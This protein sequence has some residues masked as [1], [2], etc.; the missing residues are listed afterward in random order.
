MYAYIKETILNLAKE[1]RAFH[2][3]N[4]L[5]KLHESCYEVLPCALYSPDLV[6]MAFCFQIIKNVSRERFT[7]NMDVIVKTNAHSAELE[8]KI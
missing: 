2:Y 4:A 1:K 3:D 7:S 6:P 8:V 5:A